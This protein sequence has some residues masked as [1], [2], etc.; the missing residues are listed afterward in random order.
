MNELILLA[1]ANIFTAPQTIY[2]IRHLNMVLATFCEFVTANL[3]AWTQGVRVGIKNKSIC[4]DAD[5]ELRDKYDIRTHRLKFCVTATPEDLEELAAKIEQEPHHVRAKLET[6]GFEGNKGFVIFS[7]LKSFW[8][9]PQ[10]SRS[11]NSSS[12]WWYPHSEL[13]RRAERGS[14]CCPTKRVRQVFYSVVP[15]TGVCQVLTS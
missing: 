10:H 8:S 7:N 2:T 9:I 14:W 11:R 12:R 5:N 6:N 1:T 15:G 3:D 13:E 4:T